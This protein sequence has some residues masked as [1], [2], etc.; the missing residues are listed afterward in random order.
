MVG[1]SLDCVERMASGLRSTG[2]PLQLTQLSAGALRASLQPLRIGPLQL[3]R[4]RLNRSLHA[5]GPKLAGQ[6]LFTLDLR[7]GTGAV[8][9]RSHGAQLPATAVFGLAAE[10]EVHLT[11]GEPCDLAVVVLDQARFHALA[12]SLGWGELEEQG[13]AVNWL[14]LDPCRFAQLR[15]YLRQ[16]FAV[17]ERCPRCLGQPGMARLIEQDLLPLLIE[18]LACSPGT[19]VRLP[20]PPARIELVKLAQEWMHR[21]PDLPITLEGLCREVHASRRSLIQ[22]F[23]EHLG[24]G[25]MAYLKLQRLHAVRRL[26]LA[27]DP[28]ETTIT[29]VA[30]RFGF[31]SHG[32]FSRDYR[33]LFGELPSR[34]LAAR[35]RGA[36]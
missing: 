27:A 32:H 16:L 30:E 8:P 22:G 3:L 23:S 34:T 12:G 14:E 36:A 31:L 25:P 9:C 18:A 20:R 7:E 35:L 28:G 10:G 19:S 21:H 24:M 26:L 6:Q 5:T 13:F 17:L 1:V 33:R 29:A 4:I 15:A 2:M 11:T